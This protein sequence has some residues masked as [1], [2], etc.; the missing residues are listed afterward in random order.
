MHS[1]YHI[2]AMRELRD[3]Q[4]RF[5]PRDKKLEQLDRAEKLISEIDP[6]RTYSYAYLCF[7]I[8]TFRPEA[9]PDVTMSGSEALQDLLLFV[10]DLSDA[11][12]VPVEEVPEPVY[13]VEQ[14]SKD[15]NVSSKTISRWRRQGL[16]SRKFVFQGRKRVGFLNS[17][18]QRFVSSNP[19]RIQRGGRF[20]QLSN[21]ERT[22]IIDRAR[23]LAFLLS[24]FLRAL[25]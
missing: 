11:A 23:R 7:R 17:S 10:E 6:A 22:S 20:S 21:S 8:T 5:A 3:Q 24:G 18:V 14:L 12:N 1:D 2:P 25:R 9:S 16:V 19:E 13:T 15:F 4:V